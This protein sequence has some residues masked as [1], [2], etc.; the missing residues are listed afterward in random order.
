MCL[1]RIIKE[2]EEIANQI[3]KLKIAIKEL[4]KKYDYK[5]SAFD[6]WY[7]RLEKAKKNP[8]EIEGIRR[9]VKNFDAEIEHIKKLRESIIEMSFL[10][11]NKTKQEMLKGIDKMLAE[12]PQIAG[13][14]IVRTLNPD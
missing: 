8:E 3:N 11:G 12:Y 4:Q 7:E 10:D 14:I 5:A 9:F 1:C 6:I 13:M 2:K